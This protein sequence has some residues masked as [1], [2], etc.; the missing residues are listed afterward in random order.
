VCSPFVFL[1]IYLL[2]VKIYMMKSLKA[3][4]LKTIKLVLLISVLTLLPYHMFANEDLDMDMVGIDEGVE[5]EQDFEEKKEVFKGTILEQKKVDC[6]VMVQGGDFECFNYEIEI[7]GGE[8]ESEVIETMPTWV[9]NE[10]DLFEEGSKVYVSQMT[11]IEGEQ[12]WTVES[13]SREN[14]LLILGIIF[15]VLIIAITGV[16]GVTATVGLAMSFFTL[17]FFAIPRINMGANFLLIS[18]LTVFILLCASTFIT[19]GLNIKSL[20]AFMSTFLGILI[21]AGVGY[22]VISWL[23]ISGTGEEASV[24]LFDTTQG[25]VRLSWVFLLS[26]IIGALGVLDDVTIGQA[27]SML[28]IYDTNKSL[29]ANEL[30]RKT[31]NIG[32]DHIASMVN[33]LFI[34]YAGSSFSL[35]MLLS[36]NNPNFRILINTGFIVEEITRALVASIGLILVVPLTSFIASRII[37]KVLK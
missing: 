8:Y 33:T 36:L 12:V 34:A 15:V 29:S 19:Y 26:V 17:Y 20:I 18:I 24:M 11:D 30:F 25:V 1:L 22:L 13:Y 28:E 2:L 27:S 21:I 6:G 10:D 32:R 5:V 9:S 7:L 3:F 35:V 14:A 31:M 16:R 23:N 4:L 37:V